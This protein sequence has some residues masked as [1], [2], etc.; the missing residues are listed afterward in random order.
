MRTGTSCGLRAE[1]LFARPRRVSTNHRSSPT[2][3][4][5]RSSSAAHVELSVYNV[6]GE[7]VATLVDGYMSEGRK[8][9]AW[10]AKGD[11]GGIVASGIYFYRLV[12]GDFVQTRK[13]VLLR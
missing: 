2:V 11:G 7:L 4:A 10:S 5:G 13:M 9:V 6:K 12:A 8:E 3:R 1:R